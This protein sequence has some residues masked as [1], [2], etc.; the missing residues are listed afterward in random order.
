MA[1]CDTRYAAGD[2]SAPAR[3]RSEP[4][5]AAEAE[6]MLG[7]R[8]CAWGLSVRTAGR[9]F[10]P[11]R[12]TFQETPVDDGNLSTATSFSHGDS[13]PDP[14]AFTGVVRQS[15]RIFTTVVLVGHPVPVNTLFV[16]FLISDVATLNYF[17]MHRS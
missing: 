9:L 4:R 5:R 3:W 8:Q 11:R 17:F 7:A 13:H 14:N 2:R 1:R 6:R 10:T 15:G 16:P 12:T